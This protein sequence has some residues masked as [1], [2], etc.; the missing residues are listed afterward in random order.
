ME[1]QTKVMFLESVSTHLSLLLFED[2]LFKFFTRKQTFVN[3]I[4][5]YSW[6]RQQIANDF[7]EILP[8]EEDEDILTTTMLLATIPNYQTEPMKTQQLKARITDG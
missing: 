3:P 5:I 2:S 1:K 7:P 6:H 4:R 8:P